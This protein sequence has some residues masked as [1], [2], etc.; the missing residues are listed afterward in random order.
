MLLLASFIFILLLLVLIVLSCV[1]FTN[2]VEHLG[3]YY[4]LG[5]GAV[6]SI[7]AAIGTA[8]PE[9][10]VPLVA[11]FGAYITGSNLST[12]REIGTG[13][14]L[15]APFLL[16]TLAMFVTGI[17]VIL[18][19]K[20]KKRSEKVNIDVSL[21]L[22]DLRFFLFA[23]TVAILSTFIKI[24]LLKYVVGFSLLAFYLFYV[25][26]TLKKCSGQSCEVEELDELYLT[27][28]LF[29][30]SKFKIYIIWL[31]ILISLLCLI[32]FSHLF[33]ERIKFISFALNIDPLIV[34][35]LLA[36]I[37]TE[38]PEMFNSVLWSS[39][40]KDVLALSN[41]TGAMVFQSCIPM[42]IGIFFTNW[43][44]S[45]EALMN[46]ILVYLAVLV[47]YFNAVKNKEFISS[48]VLIFSGMFYFIY[49]AFIVFRVFY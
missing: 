46:I 8:L 25:F 1:I 42:A 31:Q 39:N 48:K 14:I 27:K 38:L 32:F 6:G 11:I 23:Y 43:I 34:S 26:K 35:L 4:D 28:F 33:V 10:I 15:G 49:L 40:S 17:A 37:A 3:N 47:L 45:L 29:R 24:A 13:A 41:I 7:L 12:G 2:A 9:T 18:F 20:A 21:L 16:S 19:S 22:R 5:H 44:F 36:P 30:N